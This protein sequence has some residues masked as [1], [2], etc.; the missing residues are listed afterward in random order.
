[1]TSS[2][3]ERQGSGKTYTMTAIYER[4]AR[5]I[6]H[7]IGES[8][9]SQSEG[10]D[11]EEALVHVSFCEL[12]GDKC[13]D[14][15]STV[16]QPLAVRKAKRAAAARKQRSKR[17]RSGGG[18]GATVNS[19]EPAKI[20]LMNGNNGTCHAFPLVEVPC[21]SAEDLLEVVRFATACR[22]TQATGSNAVSS[23][24]HAVCRIYIDHAALLQRKR[25]RTG[26]RVGPVDVWRRAACEGVCTVSSV[27]IS[28][29]S[30]KVHGSGHNR[31]T[32]NA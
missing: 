24:T 18:V 16:P 3:P 25:E 30:T 5:D 15:L 19:G 1:M 23:R 20:R 28:P 17:S 31:L 32:A 8:G 22:A 26:E 2:P 12:S 6:F 27:S 13:R 11:D 10:D 21:R 7:H 4:A 14:L 9:A 29:S